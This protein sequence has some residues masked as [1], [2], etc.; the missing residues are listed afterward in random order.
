MS[1]Q[2][3]KYNKFMDT[4]AEIAETPVE[5]KETLTQ[6]Q[7]EILRLL[8]AESQFAHSTM[9]GKLE[10]E[11]EIKSRRNE[12][13]AINGI[14]TIDYDLMGYDEEM[15]DFEHGHGTEPDRRERRGHKPITRGKG[16]YCILEDSKG[17]ITIAD[18]DNKEDLGFIQEKSEKFKRFIGVDIG[19]P[20]DR[21]VLL[22]REK[23]ANLTI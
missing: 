18:F 8:R 10:M 4:T 14:T 7:L 3:I 17:R 11:K 15:D 1:Y 19:R 6:P 13:E 5:S 16:L 20:L 22:V 12:V 23:P 2:N 21:T 9:P